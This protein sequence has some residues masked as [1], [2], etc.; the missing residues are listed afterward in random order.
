MA[1]ASK[2]DPAQSFARL[3][4]PS[5]GLTRESVRQILTRQDLFALGFFVLLF[6]IFFS[7]A[8]LSDHLLAPG[9]GALDYLPHYEMPLR[10]WNPYSMSGFPEFSDPQVMQWYLPRLLLSWIPG[11]WNFFVISAYILASWFTYLY[12]GSLRVPGFGALFAGTAL[13]LCG[14]LMAHLGHTSIIH[15]AGWI[16]GLLWAAEEL[17][18]TLRLRWVLV[19]ALAL[20]QSVLAGHPQIALYGLTLVAAYIT[21]RGLSVERRAA[22]FKRSMAMLLLGFMLTAVQMV[23]T[24]AIASATTREHLNFVQFS[25]YSLS[26]YKL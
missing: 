10:L 21:V 16:P 4:P 1:R 14:F 8:I 18:L 20:S 17:A 25:S 12:V 5:P 3:V 2:P 19:G 7:P 6:L 24:A 9:D 15:A 11:T 13:G 22:F 26:I 23:S